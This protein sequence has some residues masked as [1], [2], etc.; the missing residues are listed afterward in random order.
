MNPRNSTRG[1]E[2]NAKPQTMDNNS[3]NN[4]N[5]LASTP[6]NSPSGLRGR[7][8]LRGYYSQMQYLNPISRVRGAVLNKGQTVNSSFLVSFLVNNFTLVQP[9]RGT[10]FDVN[11]TTV[12]A[13]AT[14]PAHNEGHIHVFVDNVYVT[15]WTSTN[16]IPM[17]LVP[18]TH[19][20]RLDLVNDLHQEF[21]PGINATTTVNVVDPLHS[22]ANTA[23]TNAGNA[24]YYS[25]GALIASVVSV[26]L[27]AYVA[28]KPKP[29]P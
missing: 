4:G 17:T 9:G 12:A 23:Q 27:L 5:I 1:R 6:V 21:S 8:S 13:G 25:L 22:A 14:N 24:M 16:G 3:A 29:K 11:T 20:I 19:T 18:G 28:F 15:I 2:K 26:I 7:H 10:P